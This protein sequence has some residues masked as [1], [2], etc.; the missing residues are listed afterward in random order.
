[1]QSERLD[2]PSV[3]P[4]SELDGLKM[5]IA[6]LEERIKDMEFEL[7]DKDITIKE[8]KAKIGGGK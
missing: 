4:L 6:T 5:Q 7:K 3:F 8:L 2:P 1:M